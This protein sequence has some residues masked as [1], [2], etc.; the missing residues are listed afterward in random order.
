M[1]SSKKVENAVD[2]MWIESAD[3]VE[4]KKYLAWYCCKWMC[5]NKIILSPIFLEELINLL[6]NVTL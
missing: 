3:L 2:I 4:R 5:V 1:G 6:I